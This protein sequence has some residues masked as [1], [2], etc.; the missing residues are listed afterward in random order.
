[1]DNG[2]LAAVSPSVGFVGWLLGGMDSKPLMAGL[3]FPN[4]LQSIRFFRQQIG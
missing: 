1:L 3:L 4:R 2:W